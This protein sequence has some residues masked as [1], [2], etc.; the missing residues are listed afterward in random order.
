MDATEVSVFKEEGEVVLGRLLEGEQRLG[1]PAEGLQSIRDVGRNLLD[2][3]GEGHLGDEEVGG[4][5]V[6]AYLA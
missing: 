6:F 5:L 2:Q 4:A 1:L 3:A